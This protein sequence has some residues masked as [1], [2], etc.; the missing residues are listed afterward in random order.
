MAFSHT[1]LTLSAGRAGNSCISC[2]SICSSSGR[3]PGEPTLLGLGG[4]AVSASDGLPGLPTARG[5]AFRSP[6]RLG[7]ILSSLEYRFTRR[8]KALA[9]PSINKRWRR[10][11]SEASH[12]DLL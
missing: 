8:T 11:F 9:R 7:G 4:R 3:R 12:L 10:I 6:L 1:S 5:E 2:R